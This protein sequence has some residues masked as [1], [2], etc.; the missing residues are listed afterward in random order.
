[1][2][3]IVARQKSISSTISRTSS[4]MSIILDRI[5]EACSAGQTFLTISNPLGCSEEDSRK[6]VE[7]LKELGYN[8]V[9][10]PAQDPQRPWLIEW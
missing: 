9:Y 2:N 3:A 4:R 5:S 10:R 8:V 1:M 7:G 6:T